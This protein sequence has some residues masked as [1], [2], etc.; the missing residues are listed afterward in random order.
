MLKNYTIPSLLQTFNLLE[1]DFPQY[2]FYSP[3]YDILMTAVP[4]DSIARHYKPEDKLAKLM[5]ARRLDRLQKKLIR[6]VSFLSNNS[7]VSPA[8]FGVSGSI[9]LNIH[10]LQ[11][12][13]IDL[14]VYGR[15][16]SLAVKKALQKAY[17]HSP[18][19]TG[20]VKRP[21]SKTWCM[22]KARIFP[23]TFDEALQIYW[24]KWNIGTFED[25]EFSV[26]PVKLEQEVGEEYGEKIYQSKGSVVLSAFVADNTD[27]LFL[28]AVYKVQKA[29]VAKGSQVADIEEVVSYEGLYSDIAEIGEN[30]L[31]RGKL[32]L[33]RDERNKTKHHRVV[34]GSPEGK[35]EEFIKLA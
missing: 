1:K 15:K 25:T 24:R 27:S 5:E 8:F 34:V 35:G 6:F 9:L 4:V 26:H 14:I 21:A 11:I 31:V 20:I 17:S 30:I 3:F 23:L 12:S 28:P 13:D 33:V 10:R 32:E 2:L 18:L 19:K 29:K 7:G 22:K 16:N